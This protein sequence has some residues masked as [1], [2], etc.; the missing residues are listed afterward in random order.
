MSYMKNNILK[1]Y[2]L[3]FL[4]KD[5]QEIYHFIENIIP[6]I[7][8]FYVSLLIPIKHLQSQVTCDENYP[9]MCNNKE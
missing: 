7:L 1:D 4:E 8:F 5:F 2:I 9:K 3:K 6:H